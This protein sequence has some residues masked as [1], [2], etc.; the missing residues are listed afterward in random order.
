MQGGLSPFFPDVFNFV[1]NLASIF[2]P[3]IN[4]II[5]VVILITVSTTTAQEHK[6]CCLVDWKKSFFVSE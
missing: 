4:G 2:P 1:H 5:M 6:E 3:F